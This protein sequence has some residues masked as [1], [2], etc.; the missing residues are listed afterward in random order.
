VHFQ[1]GT[2]E[3]P[4]RK[5]NYTGA[6]R[7]YTAFMLLDKKFSGRREAARFFVSLKK[8]AR[9]LKIVQDH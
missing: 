3:V 9:S 1:S 6:S 4:I 2:R 5:K 7:P 8:L